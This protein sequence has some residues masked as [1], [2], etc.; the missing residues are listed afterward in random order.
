MQFIRKR[1]EFGQPYKFTENDM[2]KTIDPKSNPAD[3]VADK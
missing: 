1:K 3:R 2:E